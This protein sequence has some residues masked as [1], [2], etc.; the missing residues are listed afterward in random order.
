[1][2]GFVGPAWSR[3]RVGLSPAAREDHTW[4]VDV[5]GSAA[6]LFGG[7]DGATVFDDLWR[8]DLVTDTWSQLRPPGPRPDARF[9]HSAVW[10]VGT[11]LVVFAGQ[12]GADFFGD[13]WAYDPASGR[14]A[15]LPERGAAPA[16]RYGSCAIVD[17]DGRLVISHGFTFRGRFDD[18][19]A[20]DFGARRWAGA[21]PDGRRPGERC[22][23]ECFTDATGQ[24]VLH[25]GQDNQNPSL[26]DL[27][28]M[29]PD[30]TWRRAPD[31]R[32]SARRL[33][34]V[35]EAG[36]DAWVFGGA[37]RDGSALDDLW[38]VDR[39][40]LVFTRVRPSGGPP[41]ARWASTLVADVARGRLLLFGGMGRN[42]LADLWQLTDTAAGEDQPADAPAPS[43]EP[44][45][46][47]VPS[48]PPG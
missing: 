12:R 25:G 4:T 8:F 11:G 1:M 20:Y 34:A 6:Y 35:A 33:H 22:L 32:A 23:H 44:S 15:R 48:P 16:A 9:G 18:T 43:P 26:G 46:D 24:L 14:W 47:P 39:A 3:L 30:G 36:P 2:P 7:R 37:G 31:P 27:W 40:T 28:S 17:P 19:R 42:A 13:L 29:R 5:E 21:A 38:R 45:E 10:V 41:P